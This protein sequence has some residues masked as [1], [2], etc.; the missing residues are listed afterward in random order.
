MFFIPDDDNALYLAHAKCSLTAPTTSR[1]LQKG[2]TDNACVSVACVREVSVCV[3]VCVSVR[4]CVLACLSARMLARVGPRVCAYC[5]ILDVVMYS[6]SHKLRAKRGMQCGKTK[7]ALVHT[8]TGKALTPH[9]G[10]YDI[11]SRRLT[12]CGLRQ[13]SM[14]R[15]RTSSATSQTL[16][17]KE[18][19]SVGSDG[20]DCPEH[21]LEDF[22]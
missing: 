10:R 11:A 8:A 22:R 4:A 12:R 5:Y 1:C 19:R 14:N 15:S 17:G 6:S 16:V 13:A 20:G 3:C 2:A 7:S 9:L 21:P 18:P